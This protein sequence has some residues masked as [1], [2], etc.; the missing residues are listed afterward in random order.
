M[1]KE[2]GGKRKER[3]VTEER[4]ITFNIYIIFFKTRA[5]PVQSS[6]EGELELESDWVYHQAFCSPPISNQPH[7]QHTQQHRTGSLSNAKS[8]L[9]IPKIK[10]TLNFI[11]N[12]YFEV[13][14]IATYRREYV[15]PEL[16]VYDL[17]KIYYWDEKVCR[18]ILLE[19]FLVS[20]SVFFYQWMQLQ[21]RKKDLTKLFKKIQDWQFNKVK[22][23]PERALTE[24]YRTLDT[25]DILR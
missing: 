8:P 25:D 10:E 17:W 14:F 19:V 11:R 18:W 20:L 13:P 3:K 16:D 23:E 24:D 7:S 22:E 12:Y 9:A 4:D 1:R 6:E 5:I 2:E 21:Q 15:E